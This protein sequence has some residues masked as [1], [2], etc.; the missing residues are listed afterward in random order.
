M[1]TV[2]ETM[3]AD[4]HRCDELF[5]ETETQVANGDWTQGGKGFA[6]FREAV[7]RHFSMEEE[8]LFPGFEQQ[9]GQTMG[10]TRMMR[11]EHTQMRQLFS[12]LA[13]AVEQQDKDQYL[14]L[15]ETLMMI[16]QQHN[17]KEEQVLYRMIDQIY[18]E[19]AADLI[20]QA[21]SV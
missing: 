19:Q 13:D 9:T 1:Q 16:M 12:D 18:G 14:G 21:E 11:M 3:V 15:S 2:T 5:A 7:E 8:V 17:M 10:P 20:Q 6:A 4:H